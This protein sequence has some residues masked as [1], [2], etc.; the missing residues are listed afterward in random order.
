MLLWRFEM[1]LKLPECDS[2]PLRILVA[3]WMAFF[4]HDMLKASHLYSNL[5]TETG[6][7]VVSSNVLNRYDR[8]I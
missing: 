1:S 6:G 2:V 8:D 5:G 7:P 4:S 3:T